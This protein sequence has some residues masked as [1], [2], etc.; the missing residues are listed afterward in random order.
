MSSKYSII[1]IIIALLIAGGFFYRNYFN[2]D[3]FLSAQ[4]AAEKAIAFINA[5]LKGEVSAVLVDVAEESGMY[6]V[7]FKIQ[8]QEQE[9]YIS[10]DGKFLLPQIVDIEAVSKTLGEQAEKEASPEEIP[11]TDNPET[12]LYVMSFCPYGNQAEE[13][14][15]PVVE[16]LSDAA[17]IELHYVIYEN[18]ASGYPDYCLDEENQYCSMHGIDE[19]NQNIREMCVYQNQPERFWNFV[20]EVNKSCN[21][22][23][24]EECWQGAAQ[25]TGVNVK[26]VKECQTGNATKFVQ[27]E[28]DLNDQYKVSGSPTLVINGVHHTGDRNPEAYKNAICGAFNDPPDACRQTLESS[29]SSS[30]G[31]G[32]CQ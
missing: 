24:V 18:Y 25:K 13:M 17:K 10:K 32:S 26:A 22:Q 28:K 20:D 19:L 3:Q 21:V 14:M 6:K 2:R 30:S 23:T 15:K 9:I 8:D 27:Q 1:I 31:G 11:K 12:H 4:E 7:H 5:T 29:A 16:L